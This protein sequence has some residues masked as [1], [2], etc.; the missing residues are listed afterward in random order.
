MAATERCRRHVQKP[1][2]RMGVAEERAQTQSLA[3]SQIQARLS[4]ALIAKHRQHLV[5]VAT[6]VLQPLEHQDH[7]R[8]AA[9]LSIRAR[10]AAAADRCTDS[11][12]RSTAA[13]SAAS[14]LTLRQ[15]PPRDL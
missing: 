4:S 14:N 10:Q 8:I 9:L 11:A 1:R 7:G 2:G 13:T 3:V 15:R 12:D 6:N 5:S